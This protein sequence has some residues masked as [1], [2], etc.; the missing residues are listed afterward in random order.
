M[1]SQYFQAVCGELEGLIVPVTFGHGIVLSRLVCGR[2]VGVLAKPGPLDLVLPKL[3]I[4]LVVVQP[5]LIE[6]LGFSLGLVEILL[7]PDRS[8]SERTCSD[9]NG[10]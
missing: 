4:F 9:L 7:P 2:L 8:T 5:L 1:V 10:S 6:F 3:H